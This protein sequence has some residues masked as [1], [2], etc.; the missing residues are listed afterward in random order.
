MSVI[1]T[2]K[3][4]AKQKRIRLSPEKRRASILQAARGTLHS[5]GYQ[6]F[7]VPAIVKAASVAQGSFYRYFKNRDDVFSAM[8]NE[9][10]APRIIESAERLDL[11]FIGSA[12]DLEEVFFDWFIAI[13]EVISE[14]GVILREALTAVPQS[15]GEAAN[16]VNS[17][18]ENLRQFI[19]E[20]LE[21]ANGKPPFRIV[22]CKIISHTLVGAITSAVIQAT[23]DGIDVETWAR[24][25]AR[26]FSGGLLMISGRFGMDSKPETEFIP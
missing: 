19:E 17:F 8:F 12:S 16:T 6:H 23:S 22:N 3:T 24:E 1:N 25:M 4:S 2:D 18:L 9:L 14:E 15:G 7:T 26:F 21:E 5:H 13:G 11:S 10:V 20:M